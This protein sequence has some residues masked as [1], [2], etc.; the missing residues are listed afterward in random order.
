MLARD[1]PPFLGICLLIGFF[2]G[3]VWC[4]CYVNGKLPKKIRPPTFYAA[5]TEKVERV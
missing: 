1:F 5:P 3:A 4:S 2:M